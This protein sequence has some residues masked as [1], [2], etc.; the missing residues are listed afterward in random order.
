MPPTPTVL[1]LGVQAGSH[2]HG[3]HARPSEAQ[4]LHSVLV[5]TLHNAMASGLPV[6]AVTRP[7]LAEEAG[8]WVARRDV[9]VVDPPTE[10]ADGT[11][12]FLAAGV[13]ARAT[14]DGWLMLPADMPMVGPAL[15]L[16]VAGAL[17]HH[18]VACASHRGHRG[19]PVGFGTE[20]FSEL[21]QLRGPG[22]ARRLLIRYPS[23][24]ISVDDPAVLGRH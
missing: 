11:T 14:A 15:L 3:L 5:H 7:E 20:L 24:S 23:A 18:A 6:L 10:D 8:R 1:V 21:V 22:A 19:H 16:A 12:T 13:A 9:L 4:G 2:R 17:Q